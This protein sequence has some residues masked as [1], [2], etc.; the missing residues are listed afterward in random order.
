MVHVRDVGSCSCHQAQWRRQLIPGSH[1]ERF[2][3][4]RRAMQRRPVDAVPAANQHGH[5]AS[6]DHSEASVGGHVDATEPLRTALVAFASLDSFILPN[7]L[8]KRPSVMRSVPHFLKGPFPNALRLAL[9]EAV[10]EEVIRQERGWKLMM[11]LPRML[12]HRPPRGGLIAKDKLHQRFQS[13]VRGEWLMLLDEEAAIARRRRHHRGDDVQKRAD[14]A[15][16]KVAFGE[17]SSARQAL[18][19][20]EIAPGTR[21]T[22]QQLIDESKRPPR[23]MDP[24]PPEIMSHTPRVPF[25]L[26]S[27]KFLKNVRSAKRGAAAG[28]SGMTVE[29]L[30]PLL[31]SVTDQQWLCKLAE[32]IAQ[33]RVASKGERRGPG[34]RRGRC[35]E[36]VGC[37]HHGSA[38]GTTGG[39][40]DGTVPTRPLD[41]S[42]QS[43]LTSSKGCPS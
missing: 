2:Q 40:R 9:E 3:R 20:E 23:L 42:W 10:S 36:K 8:K 34:H 6:E 12:M 25:S 15:E 38:V 32:Q 18:E 37:A 13:F 4:V 28:P 1:E 26:D 39:V 11:L 29:H 31:D 41:S 22:L 17:L 43:W 16:L 21:A 14:R 24:V 35:G 30:R 27:D 7:L 5:S 33:R 19:E